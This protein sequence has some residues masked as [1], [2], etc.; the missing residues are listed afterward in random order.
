[1]QMTLEA[2]RALSLLGMARRARELL[3]GQ[4]RVLGAI[5]DGRSLFIA[6][7]EDCAQNVLR[8]IH[9]TKCDIRVVSGLSR[10]ALGAAIGVTNAQIVALPSG[11][12][13]VKKLKELLK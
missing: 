12:G 4:D 13:F 8:K 2:E 10:E 6:A 7:A 9:T 11:S 5:K 3:V 1:M